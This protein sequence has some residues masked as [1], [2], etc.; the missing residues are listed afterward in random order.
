MTLAPLLDGQESIFSY[1]Q[2]MNGMYF[3]PIFSV[4]LIG[5][6]T[7]RVPASAASNALIAGL[8]IIGCGY[9][10]PPLVPIVDSMN[11]FHFLGVVFAAH[12][13]DDPVMARIGRNT[14]DRV[15]ADE[16][17]GG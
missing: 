7:K 16:L 8:V 6:L 2:K 10:L 14:I 15:L 5:M 4:V 13:D 12:G 9:F 17:P 3:I 1:L 11:E